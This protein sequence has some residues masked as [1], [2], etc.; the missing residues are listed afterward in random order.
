MVNHDLELKEYLSGD[1][2][3]KAE[4]QVF[5]DFSQKVQGEPKEQK[6]KKQKSKSQIVKNSKTIEKE[7]KLIN[8]HNNI[9]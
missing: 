5:E 9:F 3:Y 2:I 8:E 6:H 7:K 4:R 1:K